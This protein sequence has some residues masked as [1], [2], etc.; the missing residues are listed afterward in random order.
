MNEEVLVLLNDSSSNSDSEVEI[1]NTTNVDEDYD[2]ETD[3]SNADYTAVGRFLLITSKSTLYTVNLNKYQKVTTLAKGFANI[4]Q[5]VVSPDDSSIY[6]SDCIL[7]NQESE[8]EE[9][10]AE[11]EEDET[12]TTPESS[13]TTRV[14]LDSK[15]G[16]EDEEPEEEKWTPPEEENEEQTSDN[17]SSDSD[18]KQTKQQV[19]V[20]PES[21]EENTSSYT[22]SK[23]IGKIY[24][25]IYKL[26]NNDQTLLL[27]SAVEPHVVFRGEC[28]RG[29]AYDDETNSVVFATEQTIARYRVDE[30]DEAERLY[31]YSD[32]D[33]QMIKDPYGVTISRHSLFYTNYSGDDS[34]G[35]IVRASKDPDK[36]N[37]LATFHK[38]ATME[39]SP[40]YVQYCRDNLYVRAYDGTL[41]GEHR[42]D[43][44]VQLMK[45]GDR[46]VIGIACD[47]ENKKLYLAGADENKIYELNIE[48]YDDDIETD[49]AD[50]IRELDYII[51]NPISLFYFDSTE[52]FALRTTLQWTLMMVVFLPLLL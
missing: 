28:V 44:D 39:V 20:E 38:M 25:L 8:E 29:M 27:D 24:K 5:A 9:E 33:N 22:S 26:S 15:E 35:S 10:E 41:W 11:S 30:H 4:R 43:T 32:E 7:K 13:T 42:D 3:D 21:A 48:D 50:N 31:F 47:S 49:V 12:T 18:D 2:H 23:Y 34:S 16:E 46:N 36:Q 37:D 51:D 14:L 40:T 52:S 19:D 17:D 6:V 45:L 1:V